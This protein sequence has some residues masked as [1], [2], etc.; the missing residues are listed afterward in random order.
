MGVVVA[1]VLLTI[2]GAVTANIFGRT[3][4]GLGERIVNTVPFVRN[5]YSA[6]KQIVETVFQS[7]H[8][9]FKEVVL[10]EYPMAGSWAVAFVASHAKGVIRERVAK[11]EG[12]DVLGVFVP[13]TPNPT[14]GFL[15]F[16]PRSKTVAL[17]ITITD[18]LKKE[19]LSRD[20]VNRLQNLR[21]DQGLEV[22]DKINV[23]YHTNDESLKSAVEAFKSYIQKETQALSLEYVNEANGGTLLDIDGLEL[24]V[25]I[26]IAK[27]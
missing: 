16:V 25:A 13:T 23:S 18:E 20:V 11:Y 24:T 15:L 5:V 12:E 1:V 8:N 2:L 10:V 9:A 22:Q 6:L 21:K 14:S 19:G 27:N 4:I 7:Q 17:D 3:L 26:E